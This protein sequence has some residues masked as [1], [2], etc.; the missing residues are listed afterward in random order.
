MKSA[1]FKDVIRTV[2][3]SKARFFSIIAIVA[4]GIAFFSG[5]NAT[6]GDMLKTAQDYYYQ[7]NLMDISVLSTAGLTDSDVYFIFKNNAKQMQSFMPVKFVD[8][9]LY[10]NGKGLVDIDGSAYTCRAI[11]MNFDMVRDFEDANP[12]YP[13]Y[14][15]GKVEV[16]DM[17]YINRLTL[18]GGRYPEQPYECLVDASA[19]STPDEFELGKYITI[20]GD[21]EDLSKSL[22]Y[23]TF[24]IV[25]I[26]QTPTY[27]NFERG[28]TMVG[29]GKLGCFIY[30]PEQTFLQSYYSMLYLKLKYTSPSDFNGAYDPDYARYVDSIIANIEELSKDRLPIR[31][32]A[33]RDELTQKLADGE[34]TLA[35]KEKEMNEALERAKK[36]LEDVEY[37]AV[38]GDEEIAKRKEEF[39][40][41]LSANQQKFYA[42]QKEYNDN[43]EK[44]N[45]ASLKLQEALKIRDQNPNYKSD[46][47]TARVD[48]QNAKAQLENAEK[49][50]KNMQN[51]LTTVSGFINSMNQNSPWE[52]IMQSLRDVGMS[53]EIIDKMK[54]ATAIGMAEDALV[55]AEPTL[56]QYENDLAVQKQQLAEGKREYITKYLEWA[57]KADDIAQLDSLTVKQ[58]QLEETRKQLEAASTELTLGEMKLNKAQTDAQYQLLLAQQKLGQAKAAYPTARQTYNQKK[59]EAEAK[60]QTAEYELES[61]Q[62][63]LDNLEKTRWIVD[64]REELPGYRSYQQN[65]DN[66]KILGLIFPLVFFAV[67]ALVV[68][69][70]VARMVEEER[71]QMGT[72]KALGYEET[73][74]AW[75][76]IFYALL[77]GCIGSVLGLAIGFTALPTALDAAFG[78]MFDMPPIH[79]QLNWGFAI[80]GILIALLCSVGA[81]FVACWR[82][83]STNP[84]TLMR[85]KAPKAGKRVF[86]EHISLVWNALN[87]TGKVT[88]RNLVRNKRRFVTTLIGIV[89][90]S[91]LLLASF[92]L[93]NSIR[94]IVNYQYGSNGISQQDV[95]LAL[96]D[97]Q[98]PDNLDTGLIAKLKEDE[99]LGAVMPVAMKVL[100]AGSEKS[101]A[102][103]LQ[104][105]NILVPTDPSRMGEITNLRERKSKKPLYLNDTGVIITETFANRANVVTGDSIFIHNSDGVDVKVNVIGIAENYTFN[106]IYMTRAVYGAIFMAKPEFNMVFAQLSDEIHNMD[107]TARSTEKAALSVDIMKI[108]G[109]NAVVYT[110]QIVDSFSHIV[111]SL[112]YVVL[113]FV[114][115]AAALAF[116]V[117]FNL[118]NINVNERLREIATIKVLGFY[119]NEVS[120]YIYRENIILTLLGMVGGI[121][122]GL[123]LHK[124]IANVVKINVVMLGQTIEWS[125]FLWSL[126]LTA[127]FAVLVN[128]L[129]H[130]RLKKVSMV[131]S[132]KSVE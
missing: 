131:E 114:L 85:P 63:T 98:D 17:S 97:P 9:L 75:K 55:Y 13:Q 12:E 52:S 27:L 10:M 130:R 18:L 48:L 4:L 38:H 56:K 37:Y 2:S 41:T 127:G 105:V 58:Q 72:L 23:T 113:V 91:A 20:N 25:G 26:I 120:A 94:A 59:A 86:L 54:D 45:E 103:A 129:M 117:L 66:V 95:Q 122:A 30:V 65:A 108:D 107:S 67:A 106:Y 126:L 19:L 119:D 16:N 110:T 21:R 22:S 36:D 57:A 33:L 1:L 49:Q 31:R 11:S 99:R 74:I 77:A 81:A 73:A 90:A 50:I 70:T 29:S 125:S 28:N 68:L 62:K 34:D 83:M 101:L 46:Y 96:R 123:F 116:V 102:K 112:N 60:L 104:E 8:G 24:K 39:E 109:V 35:K 51:L 44:F 69:T 115:A 53:T 79:L 61:A 88:V 82:E 7:T 76:Y 92:G 78:I 100:S 71:T 118:S 80:A 87:F 15:N 111:Q 43:L 89:G 121:G 84:A 5:M 64:G 14:K 124:L 3:K 132:L 32:T 42:N 128:V 40:A 47:E 6:P 93:G